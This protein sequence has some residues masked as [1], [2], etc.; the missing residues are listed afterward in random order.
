MCLALCSD[1]GRRRRRA[2][3]TAG[4]FGL[5]AWRQPKPVAL[6]HASWT[7]RIR[8]TILAKK[9]NL[10]DCTD[11]AATRVAGVGR[12]HWNTH[13]PSAVYNDYERVRT[14]HRK[15]L[16]SEER[17]WKLLW[18]NA[19]R[20]GIFANQ[21]AAA[22]ELGVPERTF[23]EIVRG[24]CSPSIEHYKSLARLY[25]MVAASASADF[26]IA[27]SVSTSHDDKATSPPPSA[28]IGEIFKCLTRGYLRGRRPLF[29][30][31]AGVSAACF[32]LL[33]Q[34]AMWFANHLAAAGLEKK[35]RHDILGRARKIAASKATRE[36]VAEFFHFLQTSTDPIA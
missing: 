33:H 18:H 28:D 15:Q 6:R 17:D 8:P 22:K 32:P 7:S 36:D 30:L 10:A 24:E 14:K 2:L 35:D 12:Y 23:S 19:K 31:G 29:V 21:R 3:Y 9:G 11:A 5:L 16:V 34:M 13:R 4:R 1:H 27:G 26:L 20:L 25:E